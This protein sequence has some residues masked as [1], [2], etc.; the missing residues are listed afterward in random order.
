MRRIG[1]DLGTTNS[2]IAVL[3]DD[4]KVQLAR[5][6]HANG[7]AET[8]RSILYFRAGERPVAGPRAI[9]AYLAAESEGRLIQSMKSYLADRSFQA[10]SIFGRTT[11]LVA[12]L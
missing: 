5:F 6:P 3:A 7:I 2:A 1:L 8:F 11:S 4:G 9:D 12:L 10:T